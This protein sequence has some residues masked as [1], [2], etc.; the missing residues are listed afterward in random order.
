MPFVIGGEFL[1]CRL[2]CVVG[3]GF[4]RGWVIEGGSIGEPNLK[5]IGQFGDGAYGGA[6]GFDCIG[7]LDRDGGTDV[8]HAVN[9]WAVEQIH[10]LAGIGREGFNIAALAFSVKC[11]EYQ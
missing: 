6:R 5:V 7:L 4:A 2:G 10:K 9:L 8:F 1:P 11:L 3:D